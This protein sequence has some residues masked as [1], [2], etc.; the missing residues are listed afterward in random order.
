MTH[1]FD[2]TLRLKNNHL[3]AWREGMGWTIAQ[4]AQ[5]I[6]IGYETYARYERLKTCPIGQDGRFK[7][8][9]VKIAAFIG[10]SPE[11]LWP[12]AILAVQ[13]PVVRT[14]IKGEQA[15]AL[16]AL[17]SRLLPSP[18]AVVEQRERQD[19]MAKALSTL[20]PRE[21]RIIKK[22]FGF[23]DGEERTRGEIGKEENLP[24][25]RVK[26][27]EDIALRKLRHSSRSVHLKEVFC[28]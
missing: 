21:A 27:I 8:A 28:E 9:A 10:S 13:Q 23:E 22:R 17:S 24:Y 4:A 25:H 5:A 12:A 1:D 7:E 2:L 18:E 15:L 14:T 20:T 19:L 11:E 3:I 6:E 16:A 26:S